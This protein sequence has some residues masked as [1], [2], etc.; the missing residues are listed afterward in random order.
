VDVLKLDH[1]FVTVLDGTAPG[2]AVAE[3]VIRLGHILHLD[4][5]AE[6]VESEGQAT[7]LTLLGCRTGQGFHYSHAL[8]P[9]EVDALLDGM[10]FGRRP[11]L[12]RTNTAVAP[13]I[14]GHHR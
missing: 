13:G 10:S 1:C 12:P 11:C 3:A 4:T 2:S 6:G 8:P 5:V 14:A 9:E 7:E